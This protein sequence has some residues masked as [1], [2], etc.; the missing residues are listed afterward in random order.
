MHVLIEKQQEM[1]ELFKREK[2]VITP[3]QFQWLKIKR[4]L[5]VREDEAVTQKPG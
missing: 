1:V 2:C 5:S 4:V 3:D